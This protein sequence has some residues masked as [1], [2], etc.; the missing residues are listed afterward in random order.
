VGEYLSVVGWE[1][2]QGYK[3]RH[4]EW[5]R[6]HVEIMDAYQCNGSPGRFR[7][8]SD[9][10]FRTIIGLWCVRTRMEQIPNDPQ[11]I[12]IQVGCPVT[13]QIIT[14][15][16]RSGLL[17]ILDD[18]KG[19]ST[20]LDDPL[21][22]F[23]NVVSESESESESDT[24]TD[25]EAESDC[26]EPEADST[27]QSPAVIIFVCNGEPGE[28]TLRQ[29]L[30]DEWQQLFPGVDVL[31]QCRAA[32]AWSNANPRKRKTHDGME[33]FLVNWIKGEQNRRPR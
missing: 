29:E 19:S 33:R 11:W 5:I 9:R 24:D 4:P 28:W 10:A 7:P 6:L 8:L 27:P 20:I 25:S 15:L 18:P 23:S 14:E 12:S 26:A 30:I 22:S 13:P 2:F 32:L 17:T 3:A 21:R 31:A 1:R 16:L